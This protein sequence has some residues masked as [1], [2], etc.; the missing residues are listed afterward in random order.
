M[1]Q[2]QAAETGAPANRPGFHR[3]SNTADIRAG[4]RVNARLL[5]KV[6]M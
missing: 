4:Q 6:L 3:G 2:A 1:S 5:R